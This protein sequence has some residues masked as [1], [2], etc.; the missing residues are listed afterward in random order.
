M[1]KTI[2]YALVFLTILGCSATKEVSTFEKIV[3]HSSRCFGSCPIINLQV[4]KD[5]S[6]LLSK[7]AAPMK[8]KLSDNVSKEEEFHYFRGTL[9]SELYDQLI[10]ELNKIQELKFDGPNCCDAPMKTL[11]IYQGGKR[12]A[13]ETMFP[14]EEAE[15]LISI[16]YQ[17]SKLDNLT[18]VNEKFEIEKIEHQN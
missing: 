15:G 9:N 12:K 7:T 13:V 8:G 10:S 14:P 18:E 16:L 3:F 17:I 6:I 1:K 4:N 11:I 2:F 5:K